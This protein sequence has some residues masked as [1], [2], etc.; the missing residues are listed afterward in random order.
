MQLSWIVIY[1]HNFQISAVIC[2]KPIFSQTSSFPTLSDSS[3]DGSTITPIAMEL[4][5]GPTTMITHV[6]PASAP[7]ITDVKSLP[8]IN[9]NIESRN[10]TKKGRE[11]SLIDLR[12]S[13]NSVHNKCIDEITR[14]FG[15]D[16]DE[17]L[18]FI[19]C[20]SRKN[21]REELHQ[22]K[23]SCLRLKPH[24][25]KPELRSVS[26]P[27][28]RDE[29]ISQ[30]IKEEYK[31]EERKIVQKSSLQEIRNGSVKRKVTDAISLPSRSTHIRA[32]GRVECNIPQILKNSKKTKNNVDLINGEDFSLSDSVRVC[33]NQL[34]KRVTTGWK[35][36]P[37]RQLVKKA[38]KQMRREHK[39]TV[40]LAVVLVT[41]A[42]V[43]PS[44]LAITLPISPTTKQKSSSSVSSHL[45]NLNHQILHGA[46]PIPDT[47][48]HIPTMTPIA[49]FKSNP[50][51]RSSP[52]IK[53]I[54][55]TPASLITTQS[56]SLSS[57]MTINA[58]N[59]ES[60]PAKQW[61][62]WYYARKK[63]VLF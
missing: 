63:L 25:P 31:R 44:M 39:A 1:L 60:V 22:I 15:D 14:S 24:E 5:F 49:R 48:I 34:W 57:K 41:H 10:S 42:T 18:P 46:R 32:N 40:T 55:V 11:K 38:T 8:I 20:G 53:G 43:T 16:L 23:H 50:Y 30:R 4:N 37:S 62:P 6:K 47:L 13:I 54:A 2:N 21:S 26:V 9:G 51:A 52:T 27:S 59:Q 45:H 19:D 28:M 29:K 17:M 58:I 35:T 33:K 36:R 56:T 12:H 3:D 7:I 61:M